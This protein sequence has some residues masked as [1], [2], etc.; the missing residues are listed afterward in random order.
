M[1]EQ[2]T[3]RRPPHPDAV[4]AYFVSTRVKDSRH[5]FKGR[6]GDAAAQQ[7]LTDRARYGFKLL[8]YVFMPDHA[9]FVVVPNDGFS[10]SQTIRLIKGGISRRLNTIND[11]KGSIWQEGFFD[12]VPRTREDLNEMIRY[13]EN[14][15]VKA[16]LSPLPEA[17][18]LSSAGGSCVGDYRAFIEGGAP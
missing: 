10:I 3:M 9:H 11:A 4:T 12:R 17:Y 14:N 13:V 18:P 6:A 5:I 1:S 15:P 8:A 7:L 16:G 2:R